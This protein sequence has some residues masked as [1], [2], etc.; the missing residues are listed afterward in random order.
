MREEACDF[1][2]SGRLKGV[3]TLPASPH[4]DAPVFVLISAGLTAKAGPHG[5]YRDLARTLAES[6]AQCLRFDLGGIGNSQICHPDQTLFARTCQDIDDALA[7]LGNKLSAKR[8]VIGGLC[9]GAEDAF[10]YADNDDRVAG[11]VLVD[12]HAYKTRWSKVR[13]YLSRHFMDR[14]LYKLLRISGFVSLIKDDSQGSGVEGFEGSLIEFEYTGVDEAKR[15]LRRLIARNVNLH[16][17]YTGGRIDTF[18][19]K[20]QF[21]SMFRGLDFGTCLTLDFLPYIEHIQV[22][23]EDRDELIDT[24][25]RAAVSNYL[26]PQTS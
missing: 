11:V 1:G 12:P 3:L 6:G 13:R 2:Q 8:F 22:F 26:R 17:V 18:N 24:I 4:P 9:S 23:Q 7:Y 21:F 20:R 15:V 14:I 25:K 16:Y 5:L 19:H 10:L